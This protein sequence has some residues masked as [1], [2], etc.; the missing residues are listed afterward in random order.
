LHFVNAESADKQQQMKAEA[1]LKEI[2]KTQPSIYKSAKRT[3]IVLPAAE[4]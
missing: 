2:A 3:M 4:K 1:L